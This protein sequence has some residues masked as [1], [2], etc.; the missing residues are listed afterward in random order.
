MLNSVYVNS[1]SLIHPFI[2]SA[3]IYLV[4]PV[5]QVG[6]IMTETGQSTSFI[7]Q[8]FVSYSVLAAGDMAGEGR[9]SLP[10]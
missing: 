6:M 10:S 2:H 9:V 4:F 8:T 5:L 7:H 1:L 3:D